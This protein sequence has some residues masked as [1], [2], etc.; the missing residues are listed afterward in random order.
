MAGRI[1]A[2]LLVRVGRRFAGRDWPVR[3]HVVNDLIGPAKLGLLAAGI[4]VGVAQ[5]RM[6]GPLQAF[7]AGTLRLLYS[8][9]VLWYAFNL[10]SVVDPVLQ[11][12]AKTRTTLSEHLVPWIRKLLRAL[13][14]VVGVMYVAESVFNQDITA[15]LAAFG[16]AGIAVTLAAQDSLKTLFGSITILLDPP[17]QLGERIVFGG[18][19]GTVE[20]IGFRSTKL[21]TLTGH[22]VTIPNSKMVSDSVENIARRPSIRR[23]M[24]VTITYDT[25]REKIEQAVEILRGILG[26][27][28]FREPIHPVINGAEHPPRVY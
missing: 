20:D 14:L 12:V 2:A 15:W 17:F 27:E 5:L 22:L 16:V 19:D 9:A 3:S 8:I 10:V 25:P 28:G 6:S 1:A 23:I 11:R 4:A 24:N 7:C 21:R 26:E 13:L 18:H